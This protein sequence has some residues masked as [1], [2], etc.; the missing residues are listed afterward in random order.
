MPKVNVTKTHSAPLD[1]AKAKI[2]VLVEDFARE[3]SSVVKS[4]TW[5]ADGTSARAQGRGFEGEFRIDGSKVEVL[6]DLSFVLSPIKGKVE[7]TLH[8]KLDEAFG[9]A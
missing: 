6:V 1:D 7:S 4:V 8:R 2:K 9:K 3:Y 5:G